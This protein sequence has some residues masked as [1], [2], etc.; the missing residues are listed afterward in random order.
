MLILS[1]KQVLDASTY[2]TTYIILFLMGGGDVM[3]PPSH[4]STLSCIVVNGHTHLPH[5]CLLHS[6]YKH[7]VMSTTPTHT[8][9]S[10]PHED[11]LPFPN[12]L[13]MYV[14]KYSG[15]PLSFQ[16]LMYQM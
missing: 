6:L 12:I 13:Q 4:L 5:T 9:T 11:V 10:I 16:S 15:L 7:S 2:P 3:P 8:S 14:E 1:M